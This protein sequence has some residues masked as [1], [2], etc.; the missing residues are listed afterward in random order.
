MR[1]EARKKTSTLGSLSCQQ[2][3]SKM[4]LDKYLA[5]YTN[6]TLIDKLC[7]TFV[8]SVK[9]VLA[10][11]AHPEQLSNQ[12]RLDL[13]LLCFKTLSTCYEKRYFSRPPAYYLSMR[14]LVLLKKKFPGEQ[15]DKKY[16]IRNSRFSENPPIYS[17]QIKYHR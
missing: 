7:I 11:L 6:S 12:A 14:F 5:L 15:K 2:S 10:E 13:C 16:Y 17:N 3:D 9:D 1:P 4:F 8:L